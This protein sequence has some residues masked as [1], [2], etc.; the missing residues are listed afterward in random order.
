MPSK[1]QRSAHPHLRQYEG[2][3][4]SQVLSRWTDARISYETGGATQVEDVVTMK[5]C[6]DIMDFYF[7][8]DTSA[9]CEYPLLFSLSDE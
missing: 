6:A 1:L 4:F 3:T 5:D 2:L 8:P 7:L 9:N